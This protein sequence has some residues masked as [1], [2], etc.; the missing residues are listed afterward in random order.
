MKSS[1]KAFILL[2]VSYNSL[3]SQT[4]WLSR[5]ISPVANY[6]SIQEDF[7]NNTDSVDTSEG[8]GYNAFKRFE[9]FWNT[10]MKNDSQSLKTGNFN[11]AINAM[12]AYS[13]NPIC[14][15]S[16]SSFPTW[17]HAGPFKSENNAGMV[18]CVYV[19]K[20]NSANVIIGTPCSGVWKSSDGGGSWTCITESKRISSMGV[21]SMIVDPSDLNKII[22]ATGIDFATKTYGSGVLKTTDGGMTW[23]ELS[24]FNAPNFDLCLKLV[25]E[26]N[27]INTIY[28]LGKSKVYKSTDFGA[29]WSQLSLTNIPNYS[30]TSSSLIDLEV[31]PYNNQLIYISTSDL[32]F[33]NGGAKFFMSSDGGA[34]FIDKTSGFTMSGNV[35][36]NGDFTLGLSCNSAPNNTFWRSLNCIS[37]FWMESKDFIWWRKSSWAYSFFYDKKHV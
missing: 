14:S 25:S 35:I 30:N 29:N 12:R 4:T 36:D 7:Y 1:L 13:L 9:N 18:S 24:I 22:I 21:Q 16:N 37:Y 5:S 26:P 20:F 10:R 11:D 27:Q 31:D 15:S 3:F 6:Y 8:G 2:I 34:N 33:G 19:D 28:A 23:S 17:T 32:N